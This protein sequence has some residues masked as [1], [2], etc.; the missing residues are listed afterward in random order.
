MLLRVEAACRIHRRRRGPAG[1]REDH[2]YTPMSRL[3]RINGQNIVRCEERIA[4]LWVHDFRV[5]QCRSL[6][7]YLKRNV[8]IHKIF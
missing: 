2:A 8:P 5:V 7:L 1:A 6:H 4:A 3:A